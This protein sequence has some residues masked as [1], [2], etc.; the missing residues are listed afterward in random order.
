MNKEQIESK[1][2]EI[3]SAID[4]IHADA[5]RRINPLL[6]R[7]QELSEKLMEINGDEVWTK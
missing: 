4:E 6:K 1:L 5:Q 3:E 7:Q 2:R